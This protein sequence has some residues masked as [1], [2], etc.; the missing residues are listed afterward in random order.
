[1]A[2]ET[3]PRFVPLYEWVAETV[4]LNITEFL[5]YRYLPTSLTAYDFL[6]FVVVPIGMFEYAVGSTMHKR[7]RYLREKL[8]AKRRPKVN[9]SLYYLCTVSN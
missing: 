7:C 8:F 1:M 9:F 6:A 5:K 3:Y 4:V 2:K